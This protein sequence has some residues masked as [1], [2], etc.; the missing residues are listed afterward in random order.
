MGAARD[1]TFAEQVG[2]HIAILV[3]AGNWERAHT[4]LDRYRERSKPLRPKSIN[5]ALDWAVGD[6]QLGAKLA[7]KLD[8]EGFLTVRDIVELTL[9]DLERRLNIGSGRSAEI[10]LAVEKLGLK[11]IPEQRRS[12]KLPR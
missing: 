10:R 1:C 12:G 8:R 3:K 7:Q 6:L 9:R 4:E 11:L 5:E 2:R